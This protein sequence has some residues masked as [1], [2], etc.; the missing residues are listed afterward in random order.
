MGSPE[1]EIMSQTAS[2]GSIAQPF[3][4]RTSVP[5]TNE[6]SVIKVRFHDGEEHI[7]DLAPTDEDDR[8]REFMAMNRPG[9]I[10]AQTGKITLYEDEIDTAKRAIVGVVGSA[11]A[12]GKERVAAS[13]TSPQTGRRP[14]PNPKLAGT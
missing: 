9:E 1:S 13:A 5:A 8:I 4:D 2:E 10:D 3:Q 12:K 14:S 7:I 6:S 11:V